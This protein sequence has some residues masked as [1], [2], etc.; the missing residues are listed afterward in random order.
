MG[1]ERAT[2]PAVVLGDVVATTVGGIGFGWLRLRS[3][4]IAAPTIAHATLNGAAYLATR[5]RRER[6]SS[7]RFGALKI[8]RTSGS[9]C[10]SGG[11]S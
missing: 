5:L 10:S 7:A 6:K 9:K 8:S 2:A 11:V 1:H 3:G 4:S